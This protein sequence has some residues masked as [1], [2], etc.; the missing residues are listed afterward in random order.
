M[1]REKI[2]PL[3]EKLRDSVSRYEDILRSYSRDKN[4]RILGYLQPLIPP[5]ITS[6]F[7]IESVMLPEAVI[8]G[9]KNPGTVEPVYRAI[10][11][12]EGEL[13]CLKA[14]L[15]SFAVYRVNYPDGYGEDTAVAIHNETASMLKTIFDI[16][17][18]NIDISLLQSVCEKY[19]NIRRKV[20]N[21]TS[22]VQER[23]GI[24]TGEELDLIFEAAAVFPPEVSLPLITPVADLLQQIEPRS[25]SGSI[26]ALIFGGRRIP[27]GIT[28]FIENRGITVAEDDTCGGRR[29]FDTSLNSSSEYIFYELLDACSYRPMCPCTKKQEERYELLYKLLRNYGINLLIFYRD[30]CCEIS[31]GQIDYLRVRCMRDGIDPLVI[32]SRNYAD[33][34]ENYLGRI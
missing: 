12:P 15:S 10:I 21:I 30:D 27:A 19:N 1:E 34:I 28:D 17:I 20:R 24:L 8:S 31:S 14:D 29:L 13:P 26:T 23:K 16:D 33:V 32:D 6:A 11:L 4:A 5:E 22:L 2:I 18:K 9:E 3:I 25:D 7:G